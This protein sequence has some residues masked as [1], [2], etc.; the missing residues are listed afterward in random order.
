MNN[1]RIKKITALFLAILFII[2]P[3]SACSK[4]TSDIDTI[5]IQVAKGPSTIG[6]LEIMEN[7]IG[8][9]SSNSY[10]VT[11][12]QQPS[13]IAAALTSGEIDIAA[14]PTNMAASL[15][16]KT[17]ENVQMLAVGT[18]GNLSILTNGVEINSISDLKGKTIYSSGQG[19]SPEYVLDYILQSN[20]IDP[21][22]DV[23]IVYVQDHTTLATEVSIGEAS[24]AVVPEPYTT[25]IL[26]KNPDVKISLDLNEE[27]SKILGNDS[28]ITMGCLVA[29]K[30]FINSNKE[31][32]DLFLDD[33][34]ASVEFA[35]NSEEAYSLCEKYDL[36]SYDVAREAIPRCNV[37]SI[38]GNDMETM[39]NLY[40]DVLYNQNPD[41][42]GGKL[43]DENFYYK[44]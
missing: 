4:T 14:L 39:T 41:S 35:N 10:N 19:S 43:P 9:I 42:V 29:N 37:V 23:N 24:I 13:A 12:S 15:Y 3:M 31:A 8:E 11:V 27:W 5:N 26:N 6:V 1:T 22:K 20:G 7:S 38:Q 25:M 18:L 16:Q 2:I 40:L 32:I 36:M 34:T 30:D 17:N 28:K 33:Y 21:D 44:G